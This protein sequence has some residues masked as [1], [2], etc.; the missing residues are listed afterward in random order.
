[1]TFITFLLG[2]PPTTCCFRR[3]LRLVRVF[4]CFGNLFLLSLHGF[5][6]FES[7]YGGGGGAI[8]MSDDDLEV[9]SLLI[10]CYAPFLYSL[11]MHSLSYLQCMQFGITYYHHFLHSIVSVMIIY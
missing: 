2:Q 11:L 5:G 7:L 8:R 3:I 6:P 4:V 10:A 1:M 9:E